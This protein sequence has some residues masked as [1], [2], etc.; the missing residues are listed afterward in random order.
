MRKNN[1][2]AKFIGIFVKL[3]SMLHKKRFRLERVIIISRKE[4]KR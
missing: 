4:L 3:K 2:E 1:S